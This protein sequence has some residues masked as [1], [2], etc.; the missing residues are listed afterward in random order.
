MKEL[1]MNY[2]TYIAPGPSCIYTIYCILVSS[3]IFLSLWQWEEL[4]NLSK[5]VLEET[6]TLQ[7][8]VSPRH[9][10]ALKLWTSTPR[11]TWA[12]LRKLEFWAPQWM[13]RLADWS[14]VS[15][16]LNK[17]LHPPCILL[18]DI[19]LH[20]LISQQSVGSAHSSSP[21][22][23]RDRGRS[24]NQYWYVRLRRV[25]E[26]LKNGDDHEIAYS[27]NSWDRMEWSGERLTFNVGKEILACTFDIIK[28]SHGSRR[29]PST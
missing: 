15:L 6:Q 11:M 29:E 17:M 12:T 2:I 24:W 23:P 5:P 7:D 18:G 21:W 4:W 28:G 20:F 22:V 16:E 9:S 10:L 1:R 26:N 14:P 27:E 25:L 19:S 13:S 3:T 8:I